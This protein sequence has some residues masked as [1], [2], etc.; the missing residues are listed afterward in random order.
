MAGV[1]FFFKGRVISE[2]DDVFL[3]EIGEG[4]NALYCL[5]NKTQCCST[6]AG[7][8]RGRWMRPDGSNI[9]NDAITIYVS[10]GFSSLLLNRRN[11]TGVPTGVY[12]CVIPD[13][14]DDLRMLNITIND[15]GEYL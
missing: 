13:G 10:R 15:G 9:L 2:N 11:S 3:D 12:T 8:N 4:S 7:A 14:Q 1:A 6:E 5:T